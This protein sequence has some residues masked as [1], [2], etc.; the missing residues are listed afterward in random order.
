MKLYITNYDYG[1]FNG[2][3]YGCVDTLDELDCSL[4]ELF[5]D[6]SFRI[7]ML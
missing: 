4:Y 5:S 2:P 1:N 7:K 6:G 3:T